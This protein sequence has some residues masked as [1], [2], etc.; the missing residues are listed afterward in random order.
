M[1][2]TIVIEFAG[3]P[4]A[5]GRARF[6]RTGIACTPAK[7]R[8]NEAALR[9]AAA[10]AMGDRPPFEGALSVAIT[11]IFPIP[12]SWSRRKQHA[13][14]MGEVHHT[15]RPDGDNLLKSLDALNGVCWRDDAQAA[16]IEI[17]KMYGTKPSMTIEIKQLNGGAAP[18]K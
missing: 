4:I 6:T 13:A 1:A 17:T 14:L 5:K 12:I 9:F 10:Q 18:E 15:I 16:H 2:D 7:T 11:A 3:V 8:A